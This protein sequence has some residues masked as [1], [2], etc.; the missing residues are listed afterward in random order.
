MEKSFRKE[1]RRAVQW[2]L[3]DVDIVNTTLTL[4]RPCC[5]QCS[6]SLAV[7]SAV[8]GGRGLLWQISSANDPVEQKAQ[9][10]PEV[11][12]EEGMLPAR[13]FEVV[14]QFNATGLKA[15]EPN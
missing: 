10:G 2:G 7:R 9:R 8:H 11:S 4:I 15:E 13:G 14:L 6:L 1:R 12:P 3:G 5:H